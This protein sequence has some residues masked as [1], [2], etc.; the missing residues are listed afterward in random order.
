ME[1]GGGQEAFCSVAQKIRRPRDEPPAEEPCTRSA[2]FS[3]HPARWLKLPD[4]HVKGGWSKA[5]TRADPDHYDD[6]A[7][8]TTWPEATGKF[9]GA[10]TAENVNRD[11]G[12]GAVR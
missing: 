8:A 10:R 1:S 6:M 7:P 9:P 5:A 11:R 2:A 4:G 3:K 12:N